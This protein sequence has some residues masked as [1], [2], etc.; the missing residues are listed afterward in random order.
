[1][2]RLMTLACAPSAGAARA[3][4]DVAQL[5]QPRG[6]PRLGV[7]AQVGR[8]PQRPRDVATARPVARAMVLSVGFFA[9]RGRRAE[10]WPGRVL[11]HVP[12]PFAA[13]DSRL[14]PGFVYS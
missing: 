6:D 3:V 13:R 12:L 1:M 2:T 4:G 5:R 10:A 9:A 8:V 14:P 7:G 11:A